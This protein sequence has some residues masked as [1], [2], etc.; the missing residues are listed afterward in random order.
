MCLLKIQSNGHTTDNLSVTTGWR[1]LQ[2]SG[3]DDFAGLRWGGRGWG[4]KCSPG[5]CF[6]LES[7]SGNRN[8]CRLATRE[9]LEGGELY[10]EKHLRHIPPQMFSFPKA[11]FQLL[12]C[13]M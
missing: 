12:N 6:N 8:N 10:T 5:S 4:R 3:N 9:F 7:A 11:K 2:L 13:P 1:E